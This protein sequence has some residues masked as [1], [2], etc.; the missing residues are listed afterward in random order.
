[1]NEQEDRLNPED[2]LKIAE[3]EKAQSRGGKLKIFL[4]M[5]AGVGKTYAML[6]AGQ[7]LQKEGVQIIIG[8][9]DTHGR[10]DTERLLEGL[11]VIPEK[12]VAY[13]DA[14]FE[15]LDI[16]AILQYKPQVVLVDELAHS[17]VPGSRHPKRWQ[18]VLELLDNGINVYT[19]L[20]VQHI[21]SLKDLVEKIAGVTIRETVPD[22]IID[23][24]TSIELIDLTP[25]D[26]LQ[27]LKEGKVYL[28]TQSAVAAENF[29]QEDRLTALREIVLR[30]AAEKVEHELKGMVGT[31]ERPS[32]WKVRER[33]LVAISHS[34]HSQK[35][36]RI[37]RR[38]S[39]NLDAPWIALH[40][41]DGKSISDEDQETLA[42]NLALARDLGAE[43]IT[44]TDPDIVQ[45][46]QRVARQRSV[47]Q[48]IIGRPPRHWFND[49]FQ[50]NTLMD[51][52]A[53]ECSDIDLHVI[54]Q[55]LYQKIGRK[56]PKFLSST[57]HLS[58]YLI[59]LC[60]VLGLSFFNWFILSYV[61]YKVVGFIFLLGILFM[62]LFFRK[63]P[64]FFASILYALIWLFFFTP[65][66]EHQKPADN[67][68][69][70][71]LVFYFLT[72]I[73]TG[74]LIDRGRNHKEMLAKREKSIE[75]LYEIVRDI[76]AATSIEDVL[77]SVKEGLNSALNGHCEIILKEIN[78]GLAFDE[79]IEIFHNEKE[80]AAANWVFHNAQEAGW[81]TSTLPFA[82]NLYIPLKGASEVVG[83]L[84]Y[85]QKDNKEL[86]LEEKN[87]LYT[88]GQQLAN[89]I[90]H[91][92]FEEKSKQLEHHK[93]TEK[94]YQS[95]LNLIS[96]LFEGPILTITDAVKELNNSGVPIHE[97]KVIHPLEQ[98]SISSD[99]LSHILENIS[100][101]VNLN[102]G[103]TPINKTKT[104]IK[105]LV[106]TCQERVK[107]SMTN[108]KWS[109]LI[110]DNL[111]DIMLDHD[112]V[113]LLFYNLAFHAME[114]SPPESTI[115][116]AAKKSGKYIEIS[117]SGEGQSIPEEMIDVAFEKFYRIPGTMINVNESKGLGLGLAIAQTIAEIHNGTLKVVNRPEGGMTFSILL[118]I[119]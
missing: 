85:R 87:F 47:T 16:D 114:F 9:I 89:Y 71:L 118:P 95:I 5:A 56:S 82:Q 96:N 98:I 55:T 113:E 13:K 69:I 111:P 109:L 94:I 40:V 59:V 4:G 97:S 35:L 38:L 73:F 65:S 78:N 19:T 48:I 116:V 61:S 32:S 75:I 18:D 76:A 92:F 70:I 110:E 44:T 29:F 83:V 33:L 88:V 112:L 31:T 2:F 6:E 49:I 108:Y 3:R 84:A 60:C 26:L 101:M 21:E 39:F 17:N 1:M 43:V 8:T 41:D 62:S 86:N 102:A 53:T 46:I 91:L 104:N 54:R 23:R 24:A 51:R 20:N 80:K 77:Y 45:A 79:N 11:K 14:V 22:L 93:Q 115:E 58:S 99:S 68:D 12:K 107:K 67:D 74:I 28:G 7:K 52:L 27:R 103:L 81:S 119:E 50:R 34:P 63:G 66:T 105:N 30:Y 72:A 15:E 57:S 117:V 37:T 100:A 90:E 10:K 42:K 64:I 25:D 106:V 36:I